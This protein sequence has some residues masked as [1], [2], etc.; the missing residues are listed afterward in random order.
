MEV[1]VSRLAKL[2][3]I[4]GIAIP[5][6]LLIIIGGNNIYLSEQMRNIYLPVVKAIRDHGMIFAQDKE[7]PVI[8][9]VSRD[10]FYSELRVLNLIFMLF[11]AY[12]AYL[13]SFVLKLVLAIFGMKLL[14]KELYGEIAGKYEIVAVLSGVCLGLI[15]VEYYYSYAICSLPFLLYLLINI[16]KRFNAG[17]CILLVIYPIF[18]EFWHVGIYLLIAILVYIIIDAIYSKMPNAGLILAFVLLILGYAATEYR[19]I[20]LTFNEGASFINN[21]FRVW[22]NELLLEISLILIMAVVVAISLG[23]LDKLKLSPALMGIA[24]IVC[25]LIPF[26]NN[27]ISSSAVRDSSLGLKK[28]YSE[29]FYETV[30]ENI[31]YRDQWIMGLDIPEGVLIYNDFRCIQGQ[32]PVETPYLKAYYELFGDILDSEDY[33]IDV[34]AF[35]SYDGRQI[36]SNHEIRGAVDSGLTLL[37]V[38]ENQDNGEQVYIYQTTSRYR[39]KEHIDIPYEER[40]EVTYSLDEF[41]LSL[42]TIQALVDEA[43]AY[44]EANPE[45]SDEELA[46]RFTKESFEEAYNNLVGYLDRISTAYT[47]ANVAYYENIYDEAVSEKRAQIYED[48]LDVSDAIHSELRKVA[49]SPYQSALTDIVG[50][51]FV[52]SIQEYE[53][54]TE[55]EKAR[56]LKLEAL[57][58]EFE[59]AS[60]E[61][62]TIEYKG[63][64]WTFE[65]F[66]TEDLNDMESSDVIAIFN[67][68]YEAK[69]MAVGEIYKEIL[70]INNEI[71]VEEGY[72]NY[73][74]YAYEV[75]FNRDFTVSDAKKLFK[76]V[77]ASR[78]YIKNLVS[79]EEEL[80][81][82]D[83]GWFTQDDTKTYEMLYPYIAGIDSELGYS[84]DYLLRNNLYEMKASDTKPDKGFS[85]S[86]DLFGDAY[87]FDSPFLSSKDFNTYTH[88][89]GHYNA[90]FY[91]VPNTFDEGNCLDISEIQSQGLE[92]LMAMQ[93]PDMF[94]ENTALFLEYQQVDGLID[95]ISTGAIIAE[96]EIYAYEHPD[97]TIEELGKRYLEIYNEHG[98]RYADGIDHLYTWAD[99]PHIFTSPFYY[100]SYATSA[101]SAL[102]IYAM[103]HEDYP[104]AVE[105]YMEVSAVDSRMGYKTAC[106]YIGLSD[107]FEKG[108]VKRIFRDV[109]RI[110]SEK[111]SSN[112]D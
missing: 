104:M 38:F 105:K 82:Y 99:V 83:P 23:V 67:A 103:A 70:L 31:T 27:A 111:I 63:Q 20:R 86:L 102:E 53:D 112:L 11:G 47:M 58:K 68:L 26:D 9:S 33:E 110:V 95:S 77:K 96:F 52:T 109:N 45:L 8:G 78:N 89:F 85:T 36:A 59:A 69:A 79:Y 29:D 94:D 57:S 16:R 18:S 66:N 54:M 48:Y 87:I 106:A 73:A 84:L 12:P 14:K 92:M 46:E 81:E 10:A 40:E 44:K 17:V 2:L 28:Y 72:D 107:I 56:E 42:E 97:A 71:A 21:V 88:E 19:Y 49:T 61:D 80:Y 1:K 6:L 51:S 50:A 34:E 24:A 76:D 30:K 65:R 13:I 35:K 100:V 55:E 93:Y 60:M 22:Q 7:I 98:Y 75:G 25:L 37:D 4:A 108:T 74:E 64:E 32:A 5:T 91:D 41:D 90:Y 62:Y 39:N 15:P 3:L 101:L 43:N